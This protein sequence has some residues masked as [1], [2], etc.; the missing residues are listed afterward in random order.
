[1]QLELGQPCI[2][3]ACGR[4]HGLALL[5]DGSVATFRG[6]AVTRVLGLD[7][8]SAVASGLDHSV[9][10]ASDGRVY[11]WGKCALYGDGRF[12][13]SGYTGELLRPTEGGGEAEESDPTPAPCPDPEDRTRDLVARSMACSPTGNGLFALPDGSVW[14]P[15]ADG[16]LAADAF[17]NVCPA[18][19]G[20]QLL[21]T[22]YHCFVCVELPAAAIAAR[23]CAEVQSLADALAS[24]RALVEAGNKRGACEVR[25]RG[26]AVV[27]EE[28]W[29]GS[30]IRGAVPH[31]AEAAG[32]GTRLMEAI[33][34]LTDKCTQLPSPD[35]SECGDPYAPY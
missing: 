25:W 19:D 22:R 29:H 23:A 7:R 32:E 21:P 10:L 6:G 27:D 11:T 24:A 18:A 33:E 34:E 5:R 9:A 16:M 30:Y 14:R 31:L 1:M 15:S 20:V 3:L 2:Q 35:G 26:G 28:V 17:A 13:E 12:G 8:I 4:E